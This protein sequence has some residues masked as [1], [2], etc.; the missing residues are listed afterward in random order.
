[1]NNLLI[2][3]SLVFIIELP[4]RAQSSFVPNSPRATP[5]LLRELDSLGR[6]D[7]RKDISN[8]MLVIKWF[9]LPDGSEENYQALLYK[10]Y[11]IFVDFVWGDELSREQYTYWSAY[12]SVSESEIAR[13][14]GDGVLD[15]TSSDAERLN[16]NGIK[17]PD[18]A[19]HEQW[20]QPYSIF[21]GEHA[22]FPD[23]LLVRGTFGT[24]SLSL[25]ILKSGK[26]VN[27]IVLNT[28]L[29]RGPFQKGF[30]WWNYDS[31]YSQ[32]DTLMEQLQPWIHA[33]VKS[34]TVQVNPHYFCWLYKDTLN[35]GYD[36]HVRPEFEDSTIVKPIVPA[37]PAVLDST[38]L[39]TYYQIGID[40]WVD[41]TGTVLKSRIGSIL[42]QYIDSTIT[43]PRLK[44]YY[45]SSAADIGDPGDTT[46]AIRGATWLV[47]KYRWLINRALA[48]TR[49]V[50]E[51]RT[52]YF[53]YFNAACV[54]VG[55]T[56]QK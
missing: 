24:I 36:I 46:S 7:A 35:V 17:V 5:A 25:D 21:V 56:N 12:N 39:K 40:Y 52:R 9:G 6:A 27:P 37:M 30:I 50:I 23:N 10:R 49:F 1:M 32:T 15:S 42:I 19:P 51:P 34:M 26:I 53:H 8:G 54:T 18:T 22:P 41:S 29:F 16:S 20:P 11:H 45:C 47:N 13:R 33:Y 2:L 28:Y 43:P 38:G 14:Y 48:G 44:H 55:Y 4:A 3:V 31:S